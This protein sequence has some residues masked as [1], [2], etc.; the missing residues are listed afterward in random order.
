MVPE[1]QDV[2]AD[3]DGYQR[4]Q[5]KHGLSSHHSFLLG[6]LFFDRIVGGLPADLA[7]N[8]RTAPILDMVGP[9]VGLKLDGP[10]A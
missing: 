1:E 8:G 9:Q 2:H 7:S 6:A 10:T 5:V 4:D 3:H